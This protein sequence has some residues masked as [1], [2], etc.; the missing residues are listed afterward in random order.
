M[1]DH[2]ILV[3][4]RAERPSQVNSTL[5]RPSGLKYKT[6]LPNDINNHHEASRFQ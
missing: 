6:A 3:S 2:I 5:F 1:G 4:E